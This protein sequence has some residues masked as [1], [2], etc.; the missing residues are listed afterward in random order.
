MHV[1]TIEYKYYII[2]GVKMESLSDRN[3]ML[4]KSIVDELRNYKSFNTCDSN[5]TSK[6][7]DSYSGGNITR[8][9]MQLFSIS[10]FPTSEVEYDDM[11]FS[12][13][14]TESYRGGEQFILVTTIMQIRSEKENNLS[15]FLK[16]CV[17][18][19]IDREFPIEKFE[20]Q[21]YWLPN[22]ENIK[23]Y[24]PFTNAPIISRTV[25]F[26]P[27]NW[28]GKKTF[29]KVFFD[30]KQEFME[31][32]DHF[33]NKTGPWSPDKERSDALRIFLHGPPGTGKTS[34]IKAIV[35]KTARHAI[36]IDVGEVHDDNQ[37]FDIICNDN[38][39]HG[40]EGKYQ[41]N[42]LPLDKR[43]YIMDDMDCMNNIKNIISPRSERDEKETKEIKINVESKENSSTAPSIQRLPQVNS[44]PG[45]KCN[46]SL[47][48]LLN[49]YDGIYE[50]SGVIIIMST[51]HPEKFDPAIVRPGR[52][53]ITL[54]L[55]QI[56]KKTI[57]K[58]VSS[59]YNVD[60]HNV[61][62]SD[63]SYIDSIIPCELELICQQ[64]K[65][66]ENALY[67]LK[68]QN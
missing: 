33:E 7:G 43:I 23:K 62:L 34:I 53:D 51:N 20:T 36:N 38:F 21:K 57:C 9:D 11:L 3:M 1:K 44:N 16:R 63:N 26:T 10:E 27:F 19:Y 42:I 68:K 31:L 6:F 64:S 2:K 25:F 5:I 29:N 8:Q 67:R 24:D 4:I 55:S 48:G 45:F 12:I 35:N 54:N 61:L 17:D 39:P 66:V 15:A 22:Y 47:Q 46:I 50:L 49:L 18:K 30:Q 41:R 52:M 14:K 37:L 28:N 58:Y 56:N 13:H 32:L 65:T 59:Y 60:I 40:V